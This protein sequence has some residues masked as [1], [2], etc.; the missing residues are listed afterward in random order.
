MSQDDDAPGPGGAAGAGQ[1]DGNAAS[2]APPAPPAPTLLPD[3]VLL[4]AAGLR[5]STR[6]RRLLEREACIRR[7]SDRSG[8]RVHVSLR[9]LLRVVDDEAA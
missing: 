7:G 3:S 4:V 5:L 6:W 8:P 1:H 2:L 9:Q